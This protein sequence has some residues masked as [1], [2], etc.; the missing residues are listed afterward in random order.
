MPEHAL[1]DLEA[2]D[3]ALRRHPRALLF[4]HS[5]ICPV[6]ARAQSEYERWKAEQPDAPALFVDVIADR[7]TARGISERTGVRHESPQAILFE[8]GQAT[9]HASHG[10]ITAAALR[11]A[12]S[13]RRSAAG[14]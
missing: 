8:N 14:P 6:S 10:S 9:W 5:P 12:W 3:A 2:F 11:A 13:G 1:H 4:K 7:A